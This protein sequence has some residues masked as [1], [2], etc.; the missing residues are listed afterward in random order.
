MTPDWL[1]V[2]RVPS[3]CPGGWVWTRITPVAHLQARGSRMASP[4]SHTVAICTPNSWADLV[5]A[6]ES[7]RRQAVESK[8]ETLVVDNRPKVRTAQV[9]VVLVGSV[10]V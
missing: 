3:L 7:F 5:T 8:W 1:H 6:F 10:F 9:V 2:L 4:P